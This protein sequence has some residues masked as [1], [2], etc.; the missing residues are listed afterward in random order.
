MGIMSTNTPAKWQHV[1]LWVVLLSYFVARIFQLYADRLPTLLIVVF[2]VVPPAVFAIAHGVTLYRLKGMLVF[3]S[4]CLCVG[5][6]FES[7]S[8]T[9]WF[10]IWTLLLH[11]CDGA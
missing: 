11:G 9:N 2:H 3:V 7:L 6:L 1:I 8:L 5:A 4:S 10:S